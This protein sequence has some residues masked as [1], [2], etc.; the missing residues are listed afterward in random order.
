MTSTLFYIKVACARTAECGGGGGVFCWQ[1]MA[2]GRL[3][4]NPPNG[5]AA[6][7]H[8]ER[9]R[10]REHH[11]VSVPVCCEQRALLWINVFASPRT[12]RQVTP[13]DTSIL[14]SCLDCLL[15]FPF[16]FCTYCIY[17]DNV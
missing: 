8:R 1:T 3:S 4:T 10:L 16:V 7:C 11:V 17:R 2:G 15:I 6:R 14:V 13:T 5:P 12:L 9:R